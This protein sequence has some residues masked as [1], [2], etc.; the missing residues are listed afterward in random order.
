MNTKKTITQAKSRPKSVPKHATSF[1]LSDT[2]LGILSTLAL[3]R[4]IAKSAVI[5]NLLRDELSRSR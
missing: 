2:A 1:K 5:E 4:G 3:K